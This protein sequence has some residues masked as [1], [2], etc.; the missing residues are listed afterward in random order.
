MRRLID[1]CAYFANANSRVGEMCYVNRFNEYILEEQWR[2]QTL[3]RPHISILSPFTAVLNN[4]LARAMQPN[5][6]CIVGL[7]PHDQFE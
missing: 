4:S 7:T 5:A 6:K 3:S 1:G 2:R